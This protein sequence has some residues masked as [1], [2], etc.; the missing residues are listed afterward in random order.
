MANEEMNNP[1][2]KAQNMDQEDKDQILESYNKFINYLGDQVSKGEKLGMDEDQLSKAAKRVADYLAGHE[3]P[4]NREEQVLKQLWKST[5]SS[6][7]KDTVAR[8]LVRMAQKT[9][10]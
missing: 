2:Q 6:E 5:D 1:E 10:G 7:E 9:N 4:R 3:E 8:V